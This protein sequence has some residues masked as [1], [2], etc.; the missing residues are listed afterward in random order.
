MLNFFLSNNLL[1]DTPVAWGIFF[2]DSASPQ[3]EGIVEIHN[4]IMYFLTAILI[5]VG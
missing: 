3:M 4:Y 2:Q 1:F 5:G